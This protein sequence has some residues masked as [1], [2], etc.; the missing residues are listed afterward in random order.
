MESLDI[1]QIPQLHH[2]KTKDS[3]KFFKLQNVASD[4]TIP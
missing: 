1:K 4:N 3:E 2:S